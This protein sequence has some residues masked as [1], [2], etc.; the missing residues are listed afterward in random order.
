MEK[1][2]LSLKMKIQ[3]TS[4]KFKLYFWVI[5][6][7]KDYKWQL[8]VFI[9]CELLTAAVM[10]LIPKSISYFIDEIIPGGNF[11]HFSLLLIGIIFALIIM[12]VA[13]AIRT[14]VERV[15]S[16]KGSRN[17]QYRVFY[18][19]RDLGFS[20]F[21]SHGVGESLSLLNTEVA[22][23]QRIYR[24]YFPGIIK[25]MIVVIVIIT[26]LTLTNWQLTLTI[27]LCFFIYYLV[28]PYLGKKAYQ[29]SKERMERGIELNQ[30]IYE[31]VSSIQEL[32]A[33]SGEKWDYEQLMDKQSKYNDKDISARIFTSLRGSARRVSI[34]LGALVMFLYSSF[35]IHNGSLT[36]GEFVLF[37]IL[38]YMVVDSLTT[39]IKYITEQSL[40]LAQAERL[41]RL[42]QEEPKVV[43]P[44]IPI[45]LPFIKGK[46]VFHD[47][48]FSYDNRH[49]YVI[50]GVSFKI[51]PGEKV[52]LVGH[53]GS[54]K[55]SLFKLICRF[56]DPNSGEIFLDDVPIHRLTMAQIRNS[57]GYVFQE[58]YLFGTTVKE[59]IRFGYPDA[60]DSD[61][62]NVAKEANADEFIMKLPNGY[63]TILG[64]RGLN[65][66]GG[67]KTKN[68]DCTGDD[69]KAIDY[70]VR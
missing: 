66:S 59:N 46:L 54:G 19:L 11:K 34:Y 26:M 21:E 18:H 31:S 9:V 23:V 7:L 68:R 20:Y 67:A 4:L 53:S 60:T 62:I 42:F 8:L 65:L 2:Q 35:L 55:T 49:R 6:F 57:I 40:L 51:E 50:D 52:A 29:L 5:R 13:N 10:L 37:S 56:Y 47:V 14:V 43:D 22:A 12:F 36:V 70:F 64:E 24:R 25:E 27:L 69:K 17:L 63:D 3:Q 45:H 44:K 30:K 28:G 61:I 38:Y 58:T 41:Y 33:N 15:I 48:Y 1:P 32:R 16:E 39:V